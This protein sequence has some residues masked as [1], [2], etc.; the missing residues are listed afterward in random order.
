[1]ASGYEL[2]ETDNT[3]LQVEV[4]QEHVQSLEDHPWADNQRLYNR[5]QDKTR[6]SDQEEACIL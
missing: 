1:M 2:Y 6:I 3:Q 5:A 4:N